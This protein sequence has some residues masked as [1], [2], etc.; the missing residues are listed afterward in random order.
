MVDEQEVSL[1]TQIVDLGILNWP[2]QS[3]PFKS[4]EEG[5]HPLSNIL[6]P[7]RLLSI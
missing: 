3:D 4:G 5:V 7:I 1:E 2:Q 6:A